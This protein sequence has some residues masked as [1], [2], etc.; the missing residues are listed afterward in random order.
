M[1]PILLV[2]LSTAVAKMPVAVDASSNDAAFVSLT[3]T[4]V[5]LLIMSIETLEFVVNNDACIEVSSRMT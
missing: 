3:V 5:V 4:A 1:E 2:A